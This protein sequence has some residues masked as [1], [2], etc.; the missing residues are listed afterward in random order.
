MGFYKKSTHI[1]AVPDSIGLPE[2][3]DTKVSFYTPTVRSTLSALFLLFF[4]S[5]RFV[6]FISL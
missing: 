1:I 3:H 2:N 5:T 6:T 4:I